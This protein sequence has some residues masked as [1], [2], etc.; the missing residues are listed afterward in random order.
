LGLQFSM[1]IGLRLARAQVRNYELRLRK[2]K[3]VLTAQEQEIAYELNESIIK[4]DQWYVLADSN[5][6]RSDVALRFAE[7][8]NL[9]VI[10]Q[11]ERDPI[12]IGRVLEAKI[13]SRDASQSYLRSIVDYRCELPKGHAAQ[14]EL[15][16]SC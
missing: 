1:P 6:K 15:N 12:S 3:A 5:A 4:M 9:R 10:N 13:T 14:R 2:A 16:L 8:T 7:T 11:N